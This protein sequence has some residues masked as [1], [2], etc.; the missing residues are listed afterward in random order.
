MFRRAV[1]RVLASAA[2]VQFCTTAVCLTDKELAKKPDWYK[3]DVLELEESLKRLGRHGF[4]NSP[5][6]LQK[7]YE[8]LKNF[9][10]FT[11][12]FNSKL[13]M[14]AIALIK[15]QDIE[16]KVDRSAD[17]IK[18]LEMASKLDKNDAY[19]VHLLGVIHYNKNNYA[20]ALSLFQKAE[21]IKEKFSVKNLYYIGLVQQATGKKEEA[22]KSYI[23]AYRSHAQNECDLNAR[24]LAKAKLMKLKVKPEDYEVEEY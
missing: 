5:L 6:V 15:L 7:S 20:E 22:I 21:Q 13:L 12:L 14:Y 3:K 10:V 4:T 2:G 24:F 16:K 19:T 8:A 1:G 18:H 9:L 17:I 11:T 23:A